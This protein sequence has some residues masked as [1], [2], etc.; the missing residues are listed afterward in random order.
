MWGASS[1]VTWILKSVLA[2]YS[3]DHCERA[4]SFHCFI[5]LSRVL[6]YLQVVY[7][8]LLLYFV[9]KMSCRDL[10]PTLTPT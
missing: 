4:P 8:S 6:S 1:C 3:D 2:C 7:T 5:L 9:Q 10:P